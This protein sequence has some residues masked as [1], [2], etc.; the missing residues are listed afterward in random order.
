MSRALV[1][2]CA[3]TGAAHAD[4]PR[5]APTELDVERDDTPPGRGEFGFD[6]GAPVAG[7]GA[8]LLGSWLESPGLTLGD[9]EAV[10]RRETVTLGG[11]L[12]LGTS[13]VVDGRFSYAHQIGDRL[14]GL[15]DPRALDRRVPGDLRIGVRI[16]VAGGDRRAAFL[17]GDL[18]LPTGDE[19]DFAGDPGYAIAWRL[20]GRTTLPH[21]IVVAASV[22][23]RLRTEEVFVGDRLVGN[24]LLATAGVAIPLPAQLAIAAELAGVRGDNVGIGRGPSPVEAR[25]GVGYEPRP[26]LAIALRATTGLTDELGAPDLRIVAELTFRSDWQLISPASPEPE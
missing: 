16:R 25:I 19:H 21:A 8:T 11:A 15:G 2:V 23:L 22:G 5:I 4:A 7:W 9:R 18:A 3:L 17:R 12:A 6:G 13:V 1:C 20:I 26:A 10:R 24:E 14:R